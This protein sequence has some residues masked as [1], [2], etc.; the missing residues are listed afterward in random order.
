MEG[1]FRNVHAGQAFALGSWVWRVG[2]V[3]VGASGAGEWA[4]KDTEEDKAEG[5]TD[6]GSDDDKC[7]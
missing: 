2:R 6:V 3:D 5:N 1:W 7:P 4:D